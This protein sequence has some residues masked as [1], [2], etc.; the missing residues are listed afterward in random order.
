MESDA[1]NPYR[2]PAA[3]PRPTA[4]PDPERVLLIKSAIAGIPAA[5]MVAFPGAICIGVPA[6]TLGEFASRGDG[7]LG[8]VA[9][10]LLGTLAVPVAT[11][12]GF[13]VF[14][15]YLFAWRRRR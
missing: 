10:F 3:K 5:I 8:A 6:A 4:A 15:R 2:P 12:A 1:D 9:G 7:A 11:W 14:R 13:I